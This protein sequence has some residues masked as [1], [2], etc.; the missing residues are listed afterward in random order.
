M[1][2]R[3]QDAACARTF[4]AAMIRAVPGTVHGM[5]T[6]AA[7][8]RGVLFDVD[9]TL[10][11]STYLHVVAWW[12]AFRERGHEVRMVD[13]HE[14]VGMGSDKL[15]QAVLGRP[16][17]SV[18]PA[19]SR[20]YAPYLGHLRPFPRAADLLRATA[21][22]GLAVV[23]ASSV[24]SDEVDLLLDALGAGDVIDTVV[25]SG[26]VEE[27]KP[28]PDLVQSAVE[29]GRLDPGACVMVGDTA[30]DVE[31]A[32]RAGVPCIGVR[33]GGWPAGRLREAGAVAVYDDAAELLAAL[34]D[35][36]IGRLAGGAA[37]R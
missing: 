5:G 37:A 10:I 15:V 1:P 33:T 31:A 36:P 26:D 11:D 27:T 6:K 35:S 14:A 4:A 20:Y 23:L 18:S 21:G 29:R 32:A 30:W 19:H 34:R 25:S 9:G 22:L 3:E 28:E 2:G 24:K 13:I 7:R 8:R 12:Q 16:D 17:P